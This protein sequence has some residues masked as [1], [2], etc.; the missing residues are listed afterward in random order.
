MPF[1]QTKTNVSLSADQKESLQQALGKAIA[2]IPGKSEQWLMLSFDDQVPMAF[3]GTNDPCAMV[4]VLVYGNPNP[5]A[6]SS[7]TEEITSVLHHTLNIDPA[8]I[9]VA[10]QETHNWGWNGANF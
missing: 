4:Q 5:D 10:Y 8:R 6:Y 9:Y 7:L 3:A 2:I 1:I